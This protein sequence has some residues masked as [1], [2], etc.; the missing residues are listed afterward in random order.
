MEKKVFTV[1]EAQELLRLSRNTLM[2]LVNAET[3]RA[4]RVGRRILIPSWAIDEFLR[5]AN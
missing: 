2:R 3:I 5:K 1:K 4:I